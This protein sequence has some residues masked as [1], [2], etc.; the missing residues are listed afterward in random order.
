MKTRT[1][2]HGHSHKPTAIP[3]HSAPWSEDTA[4]E[5]IQHWPTVI[6][7]DRLE[8]SSLEELKSPKDKTFTYQLHWL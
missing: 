8:N 2:N 6:L 1:L 5:P 3:F 7:P 4:D